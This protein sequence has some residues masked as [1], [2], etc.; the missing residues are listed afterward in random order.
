[1]TS[2]PYDVRR[3][4]Q[5]VE[6]CVGAGGLALGMSRADFTDVTVIDNDGEACE[7]LR[8]N[9]D[10]E[11]E[12]VCDWKIVEG[13]ISGLEFSDYAELDILTGGP[14][15]Q[16]FSRGGKR[17]GRSDDR[18]MFPHFIRAVRECHPKSFI[19]ENVKGLRDPSF[20]SYFCYIILQLQ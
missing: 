9:K 2:G 3:T 20:F 14:P 11:T 7:T 6:L 16:P 12:Y 19:F 10:R 13:D 1:M 8:L 4:L 5:A 18:E 15:C 17:D